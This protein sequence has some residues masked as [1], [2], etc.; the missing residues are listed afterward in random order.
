M[1]DALKRIIKRYGSRKD[2]FLN[3][4]WKDVQK[5]EISKEKIKNMVKV[6]LKYINRELPGKDLDEYYKPDAEVPPEGGEEFSGK[7]V[8]EHYY[9]YDENKKSYSFNLPK[10]VVKP[11]TKSKSKI[12]RHFSR[13]KENKA[14]S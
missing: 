14:K 4:K 2:R 7:N 5:R 13:S 8:V 11:T 10:K 12:D 3:Y 6:V 9:N 1:S